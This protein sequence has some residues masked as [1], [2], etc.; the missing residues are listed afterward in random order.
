MPHRGEGNF[1]LRGFALRYGDD[2]Q[3]SVAVRQK[4]PGDLDATL[5]G[6]NRSV[7]STI[8][9]HMGCATIER[10]PR[11]PPDRHLADVPRAEMPEMMRRL[12]L[13][14]ALAA[15]FDNFCPDAFRR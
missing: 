14:A 2:L 7:D 6:L 5:H 12:G 15:G 1:F 10:I 3:R 8:C 4:S 13:D 9:F 11:E